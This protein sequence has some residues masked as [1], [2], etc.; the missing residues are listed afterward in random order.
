MVGIAGLGIFVAGAGVVELGN[1]E[2][3]LGTTVL[4]TTGFGIATGTSGRTAKPDATLIDD[5]NG[6]LT[7]TGLGASRTAGAG[8]GEAGVIGSETGSATGSVTSVSGSLLVS[9]NCKGSL[10][11]V[12]A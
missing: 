10:S 9:F 1:K 8:A 2:G 11:T 6:G 5:T 3:S 4:P 12:S 7:V